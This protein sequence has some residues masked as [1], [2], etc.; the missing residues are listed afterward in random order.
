MF[1][2]DGDDD[3]TNLC[4][5]CNDDDDAAADGWLSKKRRCAL[6]CVLSEIIIEFFISK[7]AISLRLVVCVFFFSSF[8][9]IPFRLVFLFL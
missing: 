8:I 5:D 3:D 1:G 2:I 7:I 4:L 6:S 9:T